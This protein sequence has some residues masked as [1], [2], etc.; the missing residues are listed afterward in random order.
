MLIAS[1]EK[2]DKDKCCHVTDIKTIIHKFFISLIL[3]MAEVSN[4]LDKFT[5]YQYLLRLDFYLG[6]SFRLKKSESLKPKDDR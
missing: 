3:V 4:V 6:V 2:L 5:K 1:F